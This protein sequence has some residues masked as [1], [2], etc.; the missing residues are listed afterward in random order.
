[1]HEGNK[2]RRKND[3]NRTKPWFAV[4][5]TTLNLPFHTFWLFYSIQT[6]EMINITKYNMWTEMNLLCQLERLKYP[7][8]P[9]SHKVLGFFQNV[10]YINSK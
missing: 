8:F 6:V 3:E 5:K 2:D 9:S 10:Q 4:A 1:M 7:T